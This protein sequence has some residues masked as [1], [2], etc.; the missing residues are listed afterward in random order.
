MKKPLPPKRN[1]LLAAVRAAALLVPVVNGLAQAQVPAGADT[2]AVP[3]EWV[4]ISTQGFPA[5]IRQDR[6]HTMTSNRQTLRR[7]IAFAYNVDPSRVVAGPSWLDQRLYY[8]TAR[9]PSEGPFPDPLS[10]SDESV[11]ARWERWRARDQAMLRDRFSLRVHRETRVLPGYTLTVDSGGARVAPVPDARVVMLGRRGLSARAEQASSGCSQVLASNAR[12]SNLVATAV[13]MDDV[14]QTLAIWL[15]CP[16]VDQTALQG[17]FDF[18]I[19]GTLTGMTLAQAF[20]DQ[21]G[22]V[23]EPGDTTVDVIVVD[24]V[25]RPALDAAGPGAWQMCDPWAER[26]CPQPAISPFSAA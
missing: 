4:L 9:L 21:A 1:L 5:S 20:R 25:Q 2:K 22:L 24:G 13:T 8:I 15:G 23:I 3:Y 26:E 19:R 12:L 6:S 14:A 7:S 18:Q 10:P 16:V 17:H 11:Q